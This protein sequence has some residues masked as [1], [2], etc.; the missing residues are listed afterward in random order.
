MI[1]NFLE[2]SKKTYSKFTSKCAHP[3]PLFI[4]SSISTSSFF[5]AVKLY[6]KDPSTLRMRNFSNKNVIDLCSER[7]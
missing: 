5:S 4:I 7:K 6:E 1:L 3:I 2:I